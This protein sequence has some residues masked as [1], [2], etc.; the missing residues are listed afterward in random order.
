[1][2]TTLY[3]DGQPSQFQTKYVNNA[4]AA[5]YTTTPAAAIVST[6]EPDCELAAARELYEE[7]FGRKAHHKKAFATLMSELDASND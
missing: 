1:M 3:K 2:S 5:G 6:A 4:L 7:R